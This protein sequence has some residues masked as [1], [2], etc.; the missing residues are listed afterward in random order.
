MHAKMNW[1]IKS[2]EIQKEVQKMTNY[3]VQ[4]G[5]EMCE[6]EDLDDITVNK[7]GNFFIEIR[8]L[9]CFQTNEEIASK[10]S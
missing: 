2:N 9:F 5:D 8:S 6:F 10:G 1:M 7:K 3:T 4:K